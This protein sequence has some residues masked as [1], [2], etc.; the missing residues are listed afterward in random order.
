ANPGVSALAFN[1]GNAVTAEAARKWRRFIGSASLRWAKIKHRTDVGR[2]LICRALSYANDQL[3]TGPH[4]IHGAHLYIDQAK[5]KSD[6]TN[7]LLGHVCFHLR[8]LF[9]PRHPDNAILC[10]IGSERREP[11]FEFG[12]R[13][14]EQVNKADRWFGFVYERHARG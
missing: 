7:Y 13:C 9:R 2:L 3:Q 1:I 14:D 8:G 6:L 4:R 10:Q 11:R 5:G 12:P